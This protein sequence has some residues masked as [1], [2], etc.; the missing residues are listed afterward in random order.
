MNNNQTVTAVLLT[1][2]NSHQLEN[3]LSKLDWVDQVLLLDRNSTDDTLKIAKKFQADV[4]QF[5]GEHFDQWRN[6]G[7]K[8][9]KN[10]WLFY[11]DPD[12]LVS[13]DLKQEIQNIL[14]NPIA[15]AYRMPRK[16]F[17]WGREFRYCNAWP[18]YVTRLIKKDKLTTWKGIIHESPQIDGEIQTLNNP[19]VH[20]TH[21]SLV[22]GLLKSCNWT[23]MEAELFYKANH[24]PIRWYHLVKVTSSEFFKKYILQKGYKEG[25]EGLIEST[26]QSFNRFMVY[27]QI[28][29][30][31]QKKVK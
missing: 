3:C 17:W 10:D 27:V 1:H 28:W 24:P 18:D 25:I 20:H 21:S 23:K 9:A 12:E 7:K 5:D 15:S 14:K 13:K 19:L 26:V 30:M 29:E 22:A 11:I 31:Q 8:H 6:L 2:N 4:V 16:N